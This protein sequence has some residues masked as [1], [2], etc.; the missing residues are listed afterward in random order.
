MAVLSGWVP[1]V[2]VVSG[3]SFAG[4]ASIAG[5]SDF[6]VATRDSAIGMG[7]PPLVEGAMGL[8]LTPDEI[9]PAEMHDR[10]GGI[11]LMVETEAE[12]IDAAEADT[13]V[14]S[15]TTCPDGEARSVGRANPRDRAVESA[16]GV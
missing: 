2:S 13:C 4:N 5:L 10:V 12:A 11:D 6:I 1:T 8:K 15:S 9:G 3:R 16:S 7:G 14:T